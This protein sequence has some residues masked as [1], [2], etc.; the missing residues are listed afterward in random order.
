[1]SGLSEREIHDALNQAVS[2]HLLSILLIHLARKFQTRI[3]KMS[4][5]I[6]LWTVISDWY[7]NG[8]PHSSE[9]A[10]LSNF[11]YSEKLEKGKKGKVRSITTFILRKDSRKYV[12]EFQKSSKSVNSNYRVYP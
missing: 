9:W 1:M 3:L 12:K 7:S 5:E 10:L 4:G 6:L 2:T 11:S 8:K